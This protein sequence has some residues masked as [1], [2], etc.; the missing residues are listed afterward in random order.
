M[1]IFDF[2]KSKKK[3]DSAS[4]SR[5]EIINSYE[6]LKREADKLKEENAAWQKEFN[7]IVKLREKAITLDKQEKFSEALEIFQ[8]SIIYGENSEKLNILNYAHDIERA[9]ILYGKNK[10]IDKQKAFLE[11]VIDRYPDYSNIDEWKI[12]LSKIAAKSITENKTEITPSDII[13]PIPNNPTLGEEYQNY[14]DSLPEFSFYH[15]MPDGMQTFEYLNIHNPVPFEKSKKLRDFR[16]SF[17]S[18]LSDAKIAEN[19]KNYKKAIELYLKVIAEDYEGKEPFERLII[20][21]NKLK[22]KTQLIEILEKA[23]KHFE[24]LKETQENNV[25][26]ISKKYGMVDKALGYINNDKKIQYYGGAFDLYNPYPI[27]DKWKQ[28]LEKQK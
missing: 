3:N 15:N 27:I 19:Q 17:K 14:K 28:R 11:T 25:I 5:T 20:I 1:G 2:F 16:E 8:E 23:I 18:I 7:H 21:Y 13:T 9:I 4:D 26:S 10:Q 12:R 6:D 22:W 24:R